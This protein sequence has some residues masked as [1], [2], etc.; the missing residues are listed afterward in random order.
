MP[1]MT[2]GK[3]KGQYLSE[4]CYVEYM[5]GKGNTPLGCSNCKTPDVCACD[6]HKKVNL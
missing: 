6:H 3:Y 4:D 1:Y 2:M 5:V